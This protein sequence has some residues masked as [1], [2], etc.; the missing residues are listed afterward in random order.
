MCVPMMAHGEALGLLYIDTQSSPESHPLAIGSEL[1]TA[2]ERLAR[3]L[4]EQAA[5]ALANLK[6]RDVFKAQSTRDALTGRFNRR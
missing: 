2:Q 4:A 3:T 5:L 1:F 6:M